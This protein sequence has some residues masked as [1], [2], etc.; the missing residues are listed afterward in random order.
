MSD[1]PATSDA[2][3]ERCLGYPVIRLRDAESVGEGLS[4][5]ARHLDWMLDVKIR[6]DRVADV[7][8][9][10][11]RGFRVIDTNVQLTRAAGELI[12]DGASCRFA[13][14][15]DEAAVRAV[16]ASSFS[17]TRFHLDP[18]IPKADADR[19]KEEWAGNFFS[20]K[21]GEWMV[22]AEEGDQVAGFV[23]VLRGSGDSLVI[24][25]VAVRLGSR[26]KGLGR[27]MIGFAAQTCLGRPVGMVVGTQISNVRSLRL[28]ESLAF[29]VSDAHYVLHLHRQDLR[30]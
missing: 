15:G 30:Q 16:A 27:A 26:G 3:L 23:Q 14:P 28:Y 12:F 22:I 19:V 7:A 6:A 24:D 9:L 17:Q 10:T 1:S 25:L 18:R 29:R 13:A 21:R 5:A 11:E 8:L 20:G 4:V 2:F